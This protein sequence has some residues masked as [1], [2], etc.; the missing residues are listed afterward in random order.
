MSYYL[1]TLFNFFKTILF[2]N[3]L[4]MKQLLLFIKGNWLKNPMNSQSSF[5]YSPSAYLCIL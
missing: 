4:M 5:K 1:R 2:V 3:Q